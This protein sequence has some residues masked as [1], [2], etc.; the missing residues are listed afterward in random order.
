MQD[1]KIITHFKKNAQIIVLDSENVL[2]NKKAKLLVLLKL[3]IQWHFHT[4]TI[5]TFENTSLGASLENLGSLN[6]L[7]CA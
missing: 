3:F 7:A 2:K 4:P 1:A 5:I 6:T